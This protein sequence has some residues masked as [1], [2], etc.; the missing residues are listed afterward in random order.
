MAREIATSHHERW[1]G[2]GYPFGLKGNDIPIAARLMA[3]ADEYDALIS[4]RV[5]KGAF[6]PAQAEGIIR[7]GRGS[8]LDPDVVDAFLA[9]KDEF[10][11]IAEDYQG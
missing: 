3:L 11:Q 8:H 1:D 2:S 7:Q 10:R 6:P 4:R 5:Y 9:I